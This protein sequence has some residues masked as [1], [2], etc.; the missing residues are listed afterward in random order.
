M[1]KGVN[2]G[3][4]VDQPR[5]PNQSFDN[6]GVY[7]EA[8]HP[9]G[10]GGKLIA[11][12][13]R[14]QTQA[15]YEA[16]AATHMMPAQARQET[17][18]QLNAGFL[19]Y[20]H[21]AGNWTRYVG[22][23]QAERAPDFWERNKS[24]T[25]NSETN[26]QLDAGLLYRDDKLQGSLSAYASHV[27]NF[28]LVEGEP[29]AIGGKARNIDA[30]RYGFEG[31]LSWRFAPEWTLSGSLAWVWAANLDENRPLGQTPP[32]DAK[33][34]LKWDN[35]KYA[36]G[37]TVRGVQRQDRVAPGQGNIVGIDI[38][39]TPGFG[40]VSLDGGLRL[41][42]HAKT[43]GWRGQPVQ[44]SL[45]R[46]RQQGRRDGGRLRP[47]PAGQRAGP[48]RVGPRAITV[49]I[50]RPLSPPCLQSA[51]LEAFCHRPLPAG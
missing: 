40:V 44:Q 12:L 1:G 35:G 21:T 15:V 50:P 32:L 41:N 43:A 23:G 48:H 19:R 25:L 16:K 18:Y 26:R 33:A 34:A 51:R 31:D 36:A 8:S 39:A 11:G 2:A 14:D 38:G 27:Q 9:L 49:L 46:K 13:R 47:H 45:R 17:Q 5:A 28:I 42:K 30:R 37:L 22:L 3:Q 4:Y 29:G 10:A 24:S 7:A 6:H 20:E